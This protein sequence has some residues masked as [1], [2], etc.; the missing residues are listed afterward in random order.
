MDK[1]IKMNRADFLA[2]RRANTDEA[3][4]MAKNNPAMVVMDAGDDVICD[5]C[6]ADVPD[7]TL[8]M[9]SWGLYCTGCKEERNNESDHV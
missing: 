3:L 4:E 2:T 8:Y 6:D 9:D 7:E 5:V 1:W